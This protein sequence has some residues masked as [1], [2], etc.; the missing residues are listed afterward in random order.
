MKVTNYMNK[1]ISKDIVNNY[2]KNFESEIASIVV[3]NV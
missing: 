1:T 3:E 2:E